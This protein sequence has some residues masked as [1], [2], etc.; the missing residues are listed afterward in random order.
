MNQRHDIIM[1][2]NDRGGLCFGVGVHV[3]TITGVHVKATSL[4]WYWK[5]CIRILIENHP[6][7]DM[8]RCLVLH[9]FVHQIRLLFQIG[10]ELRTI[11]SCVPG[12]QLGPAGG[13]FLT[14]SS[15]SPSLKKSAVGNWW[16]HR[17]WLWLHRPSAQ[18][19]PQQGAVIVRE[20]F[21]WG[22]D[23][24]SFWSGKIASM[25]NTQSYLF[26]MLS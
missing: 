6:C 26:L 25:C 5:R 10:I 12:V 21:E 9:E 24:L 4:V 7:K 22:H 13:S 23:D 18:R 19:A 14:L 8:L 11:L 20:R 1:R 17:T 2:G 3:F 16:V 15:A